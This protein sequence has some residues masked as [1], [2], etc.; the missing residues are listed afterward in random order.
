M[1]IISNLLKTV[2][3]INNEKI[4]ILGLE[5]FID[6]LLLIVLLAIL[7]LEKVNDQFLYIILILLII[8]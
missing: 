4:K 1:E 2:F 6:D 3:P 8:A 5:L 7:Y